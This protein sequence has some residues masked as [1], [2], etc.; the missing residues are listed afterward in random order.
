LHWAVAVL[1]VE[2]YATSSAVLRVHAYRPLGRAA[3]PFDLTLHAVHARAGLLVLALVATRLLLR[4]VWGA[5]GWSPPLPPWRSR[6]AS[7]VQ[8]ALYAVPLGQVLTGAVA[9]Y[10]WWPISSLH[11]ALFWALAALLALHLGGAA[12][13]FLTR[14]QETLFRITGLRRMGA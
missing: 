10:F 5:P 2:Q 7:S 13:S 14:P 8:Y 3:D 4:L 12:V 11:K 1:V 9:I 6:L